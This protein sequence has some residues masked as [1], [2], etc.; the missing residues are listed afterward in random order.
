MA[1]AEKKKGG[2]GDKEAK[3]AAREEAKR[4]K[5]EEKARAKAAKEVA[6]RLKQ[7]ERAKAKAAKQ[8]AKTA[9][10]A[11]VSAADVGTTGEAAAGVV[12][13]TVS[14]VEAQYSGELSAEDE[15]LLED[16]DGVGEAVAL[17]T[18]K[19]ISGKLPIVPATV[20]IVAAGG[21][22]YAIKLYRDKAA[23]DE[24]E[25]RRQFRLLMGDDAESMPD[26]P[27]RA[28]ALEEV[29]TDLDVS[30]TTPPAP[31]TV[32]EAPAPAPKKKKL[33]LKGVFG[34]KKNDRETDIMVLVGSD[35]QAPELAAMLAKLLTFGAPGRFPAVVSLPGGMPMHE[36]DLEA[37]KTKLT[38][39]VA[40]AGITLEE[41]AEV[42]ANVVNCMLIDIV[43]L[44]STSLKEKDDKALVNAI[45]IVVDFMNH[46]ASLYD[47]VAG[48]VT[49]KPVTYGG[50]LSKSKL[51][52]MYGNYAGSA[53]TDM[54]NL[55][56]DFDAR[57]AMLRDVFQI[58][59]KKA[60]GL[61]MKAM[62]KNMIEMLKTGKGMEGMEN[63][64]QSMG[65]L[66]G[67]PPGFEGA[68]GEGPSPEQ[69]KEMLTALKEMKDSGTIPQE[70]FEQVKK[71]FNEAFG[72]SIDEVV[73]G[74]SDDEE[75]TETDKE[76]LALMKA[77]MED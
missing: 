45:N 32:A 31:K 76:L 46:A 73:K 53:I 23:A 64:M 56:D 71:Q 49:I 43:D 17:P 3:R 69:L 1:L 27:S 33:G 11:G 14:S 54:E 37:A 2:G 29:D 12:E 4:L 51:E 25:R 47:S 36:F 10:G 65:G 59:E 16:A 74:A 70:E 39:A 21:G 41:S 52:Q 42:F 6:R 50:D 7:E 66:D 75:M 9:A 63:M 58:N 22:G 19:Q 28:S 61:I 57:V 13:D 8:A 38:E 26:E 24:E 68:N 44:A 20:A 72:S 48:G 62:Q 5:A 34:K 77:I 35:A 55:A 15:M 18:K 30:R 40:E 67:L 60:E